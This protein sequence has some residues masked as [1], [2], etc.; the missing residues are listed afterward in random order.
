MQK[1]ADVDVQVDVVFG[2]AQMIEKYL[3]GEAA[4]AEARREWEE[5][6]ARAE[7][8][9]TATGEGAAETT[10]EDQG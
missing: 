10:G 1:Y 7:A 5:R 8:S 2:F 9:A 4:V 6:R 3:G